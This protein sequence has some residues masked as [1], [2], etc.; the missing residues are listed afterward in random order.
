MDVARY[1]AQYKKLAPGSEEYT[2]FMS[3]LE[4]LG[5]VGI[6]LPKQKMPRFTP[7]Y[8]TAQFI[9]ERQDELGVEALKSCLAIAIQILMLKVKGI[10]PQFEV[11]EGSLVEEYLKTLE[12]EFSPLDEKI[13]KKVYTEITRKPRKQSE[14]SEDSEDEEDES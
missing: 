7:K 12:N 8:Y 4:A 5:I 2:D 13:L 11:I 3:K 10:Q 14:E 6:P 9:E 1:L